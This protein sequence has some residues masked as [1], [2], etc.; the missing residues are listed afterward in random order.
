MEIQEP[1]TEINKNENAALG[2]ISI[3][4]SMKP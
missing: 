4:I 1:V 3:N 2:I